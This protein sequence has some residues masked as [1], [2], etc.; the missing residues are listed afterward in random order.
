MTSTQDEQI[1]YKHL[2]KLYHIEQSIEE[3]SRSIKAEA[4]NLSG[5]KKAFKTESD[6]LTK[7]RSA[8]AA[9]RADVMS[10]EK[11]IKKAEKALENKVTSIVKFTLVLT[12]FV[13][14]QTL[15]P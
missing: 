2:W 14:G 1:L 3:H 10:K 11:K 5:L 12:R 6:V 15:R 8:Q 9:A 4:K 7:S 13:R